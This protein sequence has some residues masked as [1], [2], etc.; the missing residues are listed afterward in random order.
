MNIIISKEKT[1]IRVEFSEKKFVIII[2]RPRRNGE[3]SRAMLLIEL[4]ETYDLHEIAVLTMKLP[5]K[6]KSFLR[7]NVSRFETEI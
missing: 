5:N 1:S 2:K 6:I 7:L 3:F 4:E